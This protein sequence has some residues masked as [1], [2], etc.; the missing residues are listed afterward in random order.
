MNTDEMETKLE[1]LNKFLFEANEH[2][3]GGESKEVPAQ[4]PG[5]T[6]LEYISG[7]WKMH[8]S[9]A[10]HF[11]APGQEIVYFKDEPVWAMAYAGGM[12]FEYHNNNELT[13]E[14][15]VFLKKALMAMNP[16][17]PFRGPEKFEEGEY[18]YVSTV[19]GDTKDFIGNEKIY[20]ANKLVFE[21]NFIGGII[22][23]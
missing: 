13:H 20:K 17:K 11:F 7:D 18:K 2:G 16:G 1:Q 21:Q 10:G 19:A 4:R 22:V 3:Y 5:F 8:D 9:Y 14:A 15:F 6:E 12:E 23:K